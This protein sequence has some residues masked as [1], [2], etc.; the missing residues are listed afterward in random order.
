MATIDNTQGAELIQRLAG[1]T[2]AGFEKSRADI[3]RMM[4]ETLNADTTDAFNVAHIGIARLICDVS[5]EIHDPDKSCD[6]V[7]TSLALMMS[8][9][10]IMQA[11]HTVYHYDEELNPLLKGAPKRIKDKGVLVAAS[12]SIKQRNNELSQMVNAMIHLF[13]GNVVT[14]V[15]GR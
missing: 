7:F 12:P 5:N 3:I 13:M 4:H 8:I 2:S 1:I 10:A 15:V 11:Q 14:S 9:G 6:L